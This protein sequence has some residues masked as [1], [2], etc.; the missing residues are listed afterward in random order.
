MTPLCAAIKGEGVGDGPDEE[1]HNAVLLLLDAGALVNSTCCYFASP[2]GLAC[3][4]GM[5]D[6]VKAL[7]KSGADIEWSGHDCY[8]LSDAIQGQHIETVSYLLNQKANRMQED[9][10]G[11]G[12]IAIHEAAQNGNIEIARLLL[13]SDTKIQVNYQ[14]KEGETPLHIAAINEQFRFYKFLLS[15]GADETIKNNEG[16]IALTIFKNTTSE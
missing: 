16:K 15:K 7:I 4:G 13:E 2:L 10:Y 12:D 6:T 5:I 3:S 1:K 8:P 9:L 14:N 11:G